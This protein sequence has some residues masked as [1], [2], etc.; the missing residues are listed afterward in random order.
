MNGQLKYILELAG[1]AGWFIAFI[2]CGAF[3]AIE[4]MK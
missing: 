1:I 3:I 4:I 2:A